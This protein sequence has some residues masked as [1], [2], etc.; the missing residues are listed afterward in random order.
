MIT[1]AEGQTLLDI[2]LQELGS[3]DLAFELAEANGLNVSDTLAP[4]TQL[5]LPKNEKETKTDV[6]SREIIAASQPEGNTDTSNNRGPQ[7]DPGPTGATGP[8]GATGPAGP[9]GAT[10]AQGPKGDTGAKGA[11]GARGP[12]GPRGPQGPKGDK[13]D[14]G[15]RGD[16]GATG[17]TIGT[18]LVNQLINNRIICAGEVTSAGTRGRYWGKQRSG[19]TSRYPF[20]VARYS[21]GSKGDYRITHDIGNYDY[22]FL[23]A[24]KNTNAGFTFSVYSK[25]QNEINIETHRRV[26]SGNY[27]TNE[28]ADCSFDFMIL[29]LD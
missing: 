15:D 28:K 3:A 8:R 4:G 7:G 9:Q 19:S 5:V 12:G 2:A 14:K 20:D 27:Y 24:T 26:K 29:S 1:T 17:A 21:T 22:L 23:G 18:S 16:R 25:S 6:D 10:G 13:G 11:T